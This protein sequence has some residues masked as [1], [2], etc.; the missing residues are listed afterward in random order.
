MSAV[1][2][3]QLVKYLEFTVL[4]SGKAQDTAVS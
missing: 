2:N 3:G 4:L 1:V